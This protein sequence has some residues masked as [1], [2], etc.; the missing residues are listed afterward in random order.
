MPSTT[1]FQSAMSRAAFWLAGGATVAILFSIAASQILLGLALATLLLSDTKLR[2]P[3]IRLP[4][5]LFIAGTIAS[6]LLSGDPA[7]GLPQIRKFF[8][9]VTLLVIYSTFREVADV[10]RLVLCWAGAAGVVSARGLVQFGEKYREAQFAGQSFY[11]YY[12]GERITGFMSHW[13]TF[14]GQLMIVLLLLAAFLFFSP[15]SRRKLLWFGLL[16]SALVAAS[17][18]LGFTRSVWVATGGAVVYLVWCWRKLLLLVLPLL[19][20]A[21]IWLAPSVRTRVVS[22]FEPRKEMDSNQH[23]IVCWRT[24]WQMIQAHPWFGVGPEQVGPQ[25]DS[26]VPSDIPRPLP[27]GWYGHLHNIYVQYAAERGVPTMLIMVWLLVKILFDFLRA[28]RR[29]PPGPGEAKFLLHGGAAVVISI[30]LSGLFEMN[31]GDSEVL[32]LFL[33]AVACAYAARDAASAGLAGASKG[34]L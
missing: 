9:F 12:V 22:I 16:C 4:L 2:L 20:A 3:P 34:A 30:M 11:G 24:G 7:S 15:T 25:F 23:R 17:I 31:L 32:T 8:V 14:G 18:L 19:L 6:L 27:K 29:L 13:M 33:A 10:R 21:G 26:Y 28:V 5:A 1:S